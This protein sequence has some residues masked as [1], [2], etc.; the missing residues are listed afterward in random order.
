MEEK[1]LVRCF[2]ALELSRE[3]I[4]ELERIQDLI[5]KKNLF[6]GKFTEP[7]NFHLTLKF[8]GEIENSAVEKVK[9]VL[10]EIKF[11]EFEVTLGEA[12]VFSKRS[13]KLLW[14]RV[15]GS[16]I[17][18]LQKAID[19]LLLG[20]FEPEQRFMSHITIARMK[21]VSSNKEFLE[22]IKAIKIKKIKFKVKEFFLKKSELTPQGPIYTD[23][24]RYVSG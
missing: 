6:Y 21:K 20:S 15:Q 22:Y 16:G 19:N 4:S 24:G 10:E 3:A 9:K 14:V 7:E 23:L 17:W 13:L 11:N 2:I 12:G 1:N 18:D 5:K 8:L